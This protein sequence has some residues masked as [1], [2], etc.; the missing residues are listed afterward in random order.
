MERGRLSLGRG[1]RTLLVCGVFAAGTAAA[2]YR[3]LPPRTDVPYGPVPALAPVGMSLTNGVMLKH[4]R[5]HFW[6]G[7]GDGDAASQ[8]G[9][10]G[11]WLAWL[12]GADAVTLNH[13]MKVNARVA[14]D[15]V[16]EVWDEPDLAI[17][18]WRREAVQL[19]LLCDFFHSHE[20]GTGGQTC[21]AEAYQLSLKDPAL[22]EIY[23]HLGHHLGFDTGSDEG[24]AFSLAH[25]K[26]LF[27]Y[28]KQEPYTSY[29]EIAREPGANPS[30]AR[31]RRGFREWA[32]RK[33]GGDL[34]AA[35]AVWGVKHASWDDV[36]P[37][38]LDKARFPAKHSY[39]DILV[40][41]R[42][43]AEAPNFYAD[44]RRFLEDDTTRMMER[45]L[46]A[47]RR[48][49]PWSPVTVDV[50]GHTN[51]D[52]AYAAFVPERISPLVDLF[53]IHYGTQLF[54]YGGRPWDRASVLIATAAPLFW[55]SYFRVNAD[56]AIVNA[57]N[58]FGDARAT[59]T[60]ADRMRENDMGQLCAQKWRIAKDAGWKQTRTWANPDFDDSS[61]DEI[62]LP[63]C[64][65]QATGTAYEG[66]QGTCW[67]RRTF[68]VSA[69]RKQDFVDG[70][71]VF[72]L[73]GKGVAQQGDV[74]LNG[75]R[76]NQKKVI[77]WTTPY[78]FDVGPFLNWGGRN[79]LVWRVEGMGRS[80]NG[81]RFP[82]YI[83]AED[84]LSK[85][86]PFDERMCRFMS[87][88]H[89]MGGL[90]GIWMWHWH[91][92]GVRAYMP[93]LKAQLNAVA[94]AALP[95]IRNR[96]GR[97]AYLYAF[98][99]GPGL[100]FG[101]DA[102]HYVDYHDALVFSGVNPDVFGEARFRRDVTP[103]KYPLLFVPMTPC[104]DAAT[105]E[106]FKRYVAE[107]GTAVVTDGT[108][109]RT[110]DRYADTDFAEYLRA[111]DFGKG[112]IL[113][114]PSRAELGE[115]MDRLVGI[116]PP[117]E[118]RIGA[119]PST[120]KPLVE[121]IVA[122][123]AERKV[124]YLAN[125]GGLAQELTVTLPPSLDGWTV[126]PVV[127][128]FEKVSSAPG[129]LAVTVPSQDV[130]VALLSRPGT[131][132]PVIP[133]VSPL[134]QAKL[135]ELAQRLAQAREIPCEKADVVFVG[136]AE[137]KRGAR[138]QGIEKHPELLRAFARMGLSCAET[139]VARLKD[140]D[141]SAAKLVIL[142]ESNS[143]CGVKPDRQA[144]GLM[145]GILE[146]YVR[147]GGSL[148]VLADSAGSRN[149]DALSLRELAGRFGIT[150]SRVA[151]M[152]VARGQFGDPSQILSD[153]IPTSPLSEGVGKV[154][155]YRLRPLS[156]LS[157]KR[158]PKDV[159]TFPVV[160]V[161]GGAAVMAGLCG[162]GRFLVSAD[163]SMFAPLRIEQGNNAELLANTLGWLLR[164]PADATARAACR[165]NLFFT[166]VDFKRILEEESR[167]VR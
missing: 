73:I 6:I 139:S 133:K 52:D 124:L 32:K 140:V 115:L 8:Q 130:A 18:S 36:T 148:M 29:M 156:A 21:T 75:H 53:S 144:K 161:T 45:E 24:L 109:L 152:D 143:N 71:R 17:Q 43:R 116:L 4:G 56:G 12:Q 74:W 22:H 126:T 103:E 79:V 167:T 163:I 125:W 34:A 114:F 78:A 86:V 165:R 136:S 48:L 65:D 141:L 85:P 96:R 37:P 166:E 62:A 60:D 26:A 39:E 108:F 106:H 111:G 7:N 81:L 107:G 101:G 154:Q 61:W 38:H 151:A 40:R 41:N 42:A 105:Y 132:T 44:W 97:V 80:D 119:R 131:E 87:F 127:G 95:E 3:V 55:Q 91:G 137:R 164:K 88:G 118:L 112:R 162:K 59:M 153:D 134:R 94:E 98:D 19:G 1:M 147:R 15:G 16:V 11:V 84:Q 138:V 113:V 30:N 27:D 23:Y 63:G 122:G 89:L 76:L 10:F 50:R 9:H 102:R 146:A 104:V 25:R 100:P 110:T 33:Y 20:P 13:G 64:W 158:R 57:E 83:L 58:I 129:T 35:D 160:N 46:G 159:E 155:L 67:L 2:G 49:A 77:G 70:S 128:S 121:R 93:R 90:S 82:S 145:V 31:V 150:A 135:D 72:K 149:C 14:D 142:V 157:G 28:L 69:A 99:N 123:G 51:R 92:D 68:H 54:D 66:F 120:E 47:L 117:S 5:P